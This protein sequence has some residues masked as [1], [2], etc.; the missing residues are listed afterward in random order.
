M[1][2]AAFSNKISKLSGSLS[3]SLQLEPEPEADEL[4]C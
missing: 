1:V 2:T 3:G 4:L